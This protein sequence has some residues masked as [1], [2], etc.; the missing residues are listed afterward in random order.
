MHHTVR[1]GRPTLAPIAAGTPKPMVPAPPELTQVPGSS[2]FQN[3]DAHIWCWPTPDGDDRAR[4]GLG[5][6]GLDDV[7]GAQRARRSTAPRRRADTAPASRGS[8][9]T[10]RRGSS[11]SPTRRRRRGAPRRRCSGS[12]TSALADLVELRPVDVD[13]DD[14]GARRRTPGSCPSPGRR[15]A[16][17]ARSA[18]R[19]S[20]SR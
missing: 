7:L 1:S 13:V 3:C 2:N 6:D 8:R 5:G 19:T 10:R 16:R 4:R 12:A 15:S 11:A 18:G 14:L 20:G 9:P 17:R